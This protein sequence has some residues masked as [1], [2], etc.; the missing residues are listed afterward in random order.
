M[1]STAVPTNRAEFVSQLAEQRDRYEHA[2]QELRAELRRINGELAR[3]EAAG[4]AVEEL[5]LIEAPELVAKL[6]PE[7]EVDLKLLPLPSTRPFLEA[8]YELLLEGGVPVYYR[9]LAERIRARGVVIPGQNPAQNLYAHLRRDRR[10]VL[11]GPGTFGLQPA[12]IHRP[13]EPTSS[14]AS[15]GKSPAL[16]RKRRRPRKRSTKG[17]A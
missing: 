11:T 7:A 9:E 15:T 5:L 12:M 2:K 14:R 8:A 1:E 17:K 10:F 16:R 6:S 13:V 4:R 3:V